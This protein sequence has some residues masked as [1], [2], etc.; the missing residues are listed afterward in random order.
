MKRNWG[1]LAIILGG[2][3]GILG[4]LGTA[5][6]VINRL[7]PVLY[8]DWIV[9]YSAGTAIRAGMSDLVYDGT[10]LT[11]FEAALLGPWFTGPVTLHPFLYPPPFLLLLA[12]LSLLPFAV[13]YVGF[14]MASAL[15]AVA[16]LARRERGGYDWWRG[17]MLLA[18]IPACTNALTGQNGAL[19]L[20]L[21]VSGFRLLER[22][23]AWAGAVLGLLSYKPQLFL[24]V[25]VALAA[26]RAWRALAACAVSAAA[27]VLLSALAFGP[28]TWLLWIKAGVEARD[29]S[30]AEWFRETY[31]GGYGIYVVAA[32]FGAPDLVAK[33]LQAGAILIGAGA[34]YWAYAREGRTEAKLA[35]LLAAMIAAAPHLE[36]YDMMLLSAAAILIFTNAA[37]EI[38]FAE[39]VLLAA[40][41]ILPLLRPSL[42]VAGLLVPVVLFGSVYVALRA[43]APQSTRPRTSALVDA[44]PVQD[45]RVG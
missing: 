42:T 13:S 37:G 19:S 21:T 33:A 7:G 12:P 40:I 20:A 41:W 36:A 6:V 25:P 22:R 32:R 30:Y 35:V 11:A 44:R 45:E 3:G 18:F 15:A 34:T 1:P 28:E 39:F 16:A 29:P 9:F 43:L 31:L 27:L 24:L 17:L 38:G 23:P 26:A 5:S 8:Q 14:D 4:W 10:H 2:V